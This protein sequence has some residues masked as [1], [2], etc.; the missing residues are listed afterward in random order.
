MV[1]ALYGAV[2]LAIDGV[3]SLLADRDVIVE[4]DAGPLVGP[5][6]AFSAVCVVF[7]S[8]LSGLRP[9]PG[10]VRF[11]LGPALLTGLAVY[12]LSP[13]IGAIVYVFGQEQLL[14]GVHF[15]VRYLLSP[16]VLAAALLAVV[17]I[18]LLPAI[19]LAR[20]RAA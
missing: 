13:S 17:T 6:M 15:F 20:S 3:I 12:L 18:L 14:S 8:V 7:L 19:A 1:A 2:L 5:I 16:F 11:P 4:A 9:V 10:G